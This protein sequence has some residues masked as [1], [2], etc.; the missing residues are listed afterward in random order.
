MAAY[1]KVSAL[2]MLCTLSL[3]TVAQAND[4]VSAT[5]QAVPIESPVKA[6]PA[7]SDSTIPH[8][9][10]VHLMVLNE[11][12][13]KTH[14]AGHRFPLRVDK[15]VMVGQHVAIPV[16]AKAWGEVTTAA[17]SGNVGKPGSLSARLLYVEVEGRELAISGETSARG[18]G[19]GA[20]TVMGILALGPLGLFAK[21][22]N[23]K[24]KAG[25]RMTAFTV[26]DFP[27]TPPQ[28]SDAPANPLP[29]R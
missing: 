25:E 24:I 20:E 13:T 6:P 3:T 21:G 5:I 19:G 15:P 4:V 27:L 8:D 14:P 28:Q 1:R 29:P 10:P 12:T 17:A 18:K 16:G 2:G 9:T 7:Q 23:A 11:V 26:G 22:N